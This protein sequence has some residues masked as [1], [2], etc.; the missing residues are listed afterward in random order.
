MYP[1]DVKPVEQA[2][3]ARGLLDPAFVD[4]AFGTLTISAYSSLQ[5]SYGLSGRDADGVPG[6]TSLNRLGQ[7]S[8]LFSVTDGQPALGFAQGI[9]MSDVI[10][11]RVTDASAIAAIVRV[12]ELLD[13]PVTSWL[14]GYK[15]LTFRES[16]YNFNAVNNNDANAHGPFQSDGCHLYC[17][18]GVAQCIPPVFAHYHQ[19]GTSNHIYDGVANIASSMNYVMDRYGVARDGHDLAAKVQQADSNR[20]PHWY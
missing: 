7:E 20:P 6:S 16:S 12:C 5:R 14:P 18:R 10:F 1:A 2:L 17:S 15:T 8:G 19:P 3:A 11:D 13:I 4:G 9:R